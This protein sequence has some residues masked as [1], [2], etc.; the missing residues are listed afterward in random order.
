VRLVAAQ[1]DA[2]HKIEGMQFRRCDKIRNAKFEKL[3]QFS[4]R[5]FYAPMSVGVRGRIPVS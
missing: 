4:L 5:G 1:C 3:L 2:R